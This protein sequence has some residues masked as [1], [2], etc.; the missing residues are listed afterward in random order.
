MKRLALV[1]TSLA[2]AAV[3]SGA[4]AVFASTSTVDDIEAIQAEIGERKAEIE[5]E[6]E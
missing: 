5:Q 3:Q 2:L 4:P 1:I 6:T